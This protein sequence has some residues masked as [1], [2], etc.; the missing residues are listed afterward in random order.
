[1]DAACKTGG[2][3]LIR[4]R[5]WEARIPTAKDAA[6]SCVSDGTPPLSD[7]RTR[8]PGVP[9]LTPG[10]AQ[11][12]FFDFT[13][14]TTRTP[15]RFAVFIV[16]R[17]YSAAAWSSSRGTPFGPCNAFVKS[18]QAVMIASVGDWPLEHFE[19]LSFIGFPR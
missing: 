9:P 19:I 15:W 6:A 7:A 5:F 12:G 13:G 4:L 8:K 16:S 1:M 17:R 14:G 2:K 3:Y 18:L 10:T 11:K